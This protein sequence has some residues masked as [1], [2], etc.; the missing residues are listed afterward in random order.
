[1]LYASESKASDADLARAA[2][3]ADVPGDAADEIMITT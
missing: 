2:E 1:M 3:D